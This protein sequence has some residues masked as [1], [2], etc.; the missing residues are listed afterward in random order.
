MKY[1]SMLELR[2]NAIGKGIY[3]TKDIPKGAVLAQWEPL[4]TEEQ[5]LAIPR[6]NLEI[7]YITKVGE[8]H[9]TLKSNKIDDYFNHSCEPNAGLNFNTLLLISIKDIAKDEEVTWDYST[10]MDKSSLELFPEWRMM[11]ECGVS[12]CRKIVD[13]FDTLPK[14]KR[15]QYSVL[16]IVPNFLKQYV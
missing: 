7:D 4:V 5:L 8:K 1:G 10:S 6:D 12:T 9:Y 16:M 14:E 2:E 3:A 11:C 13:S 15:L